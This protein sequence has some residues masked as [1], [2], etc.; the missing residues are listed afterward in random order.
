MRLFSFYVTIEFQVDAYGELFNDPSLLWPT[1][2]LE[3]SMF[4]QD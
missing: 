3:Y 1:Y 4:Q 2:I